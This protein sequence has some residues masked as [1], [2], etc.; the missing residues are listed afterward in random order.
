MMVVDELLVF[1]TWIL[2]VLSFYRSCDCGPSSW[3]SGC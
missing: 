3:F 1:M 2:S